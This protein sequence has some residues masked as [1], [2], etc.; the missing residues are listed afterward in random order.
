MTHVRFTIIKNAAANIIRGGA[1]AAVAL[2]LPH[3]LAK[4]LDHG[5]FAA[6]SLMLQIAAYASYVDFGL[7]TAVARFLSRYTELGD[8]ES[9]NSLVSTAFAFLTGAAALATV[10]FAVIIW[11]LP[12]IFQ[13][14]PSPLLGEFRWAVAIVA[15]GA[16]LQLPL[17]VFSGVLIG[18][19]KN[20]YV[21]L[22]VGCSRMVGAAAVLLAVRS[23]SSLIVLGAC[24]SVTAVLG[25]GAQF[26]AAKHLWPLMALSR[27]LVRRAMATELAKFCMGLTAWSTSMF[28]VTGLNLTIVGTVDFRAVG[29]YSV[30]TALINVLSGVNSAACAAFMTPI[31]A[32]HA[33]GETEKIRHLILTASRWNTFANVTIAAGTFLFGYPLLRLWVGA[34]YASSAEPI[35]EILIAA[36]AIRL[37]ALPYSTM[38]IATGQQRLGIAQGVVEGVVN[39]IASVAGAMLFGPIGVAWGT[40]AGAVS[41]LV[42]ACVLTAKWAKEIPLGRWSLALESIVRPLA[43]ALPLLAFA[44]TAR[45]RN[46]TD[47]SAAAAIGCAALT[48]VLTVKYGKLFGSAS[49]NSL[50]AA[51][52]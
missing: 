25:G 11:Q 6:W 31:S 20:E 1:T 42:W 23:T 18:L 8:D 27:S 34:D 17:S 14:V 12:R 15:A 50:P 37:A 32:L 9:R 26:L 19:H 36:N 21:A 28:L 22:A 45:L 13:G 40:L 48:C 16:T 52:G 44:A 30:A 33:A 41:G 4:G 39:L 47:S 24:V 3:F 46:S 7:Q 2:A 10:G 35:A 5:R 51:N 49:R 29:Y 38:L 43:C